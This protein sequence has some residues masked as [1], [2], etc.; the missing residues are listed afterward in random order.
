MFHDEQSISSPAKTLKFERIINRNRLTL[1]G[2]G[3][4]S[5]MSCECVCTN[6]NFTQADGHNAVALKQGGFM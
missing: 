5:A 4:V 2:V 1:N 3:P 6:C